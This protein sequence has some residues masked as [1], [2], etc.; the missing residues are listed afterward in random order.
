MRNVPKVIKAGLLRLIASLVPAALVFML[1]P[2]TTPAQSTDQEIPTPI[3]AADLSAEIPVR[4]LGDARRT[5]HFFIFT[6]TPGDLMVSVESRNLNG[7][8]DVFTAGSFRPL[9][10]ISLFASE[11]A[12]RTSKSVYLRAR[13]DLILRVEARSPNDEPGTYRLQFG[14]SFEPFSGEIAVAETPPESDEKAATTPRKG[15]RVNAV[16]ARID[17]PASVVEEK[18]A[19]EQPAI[20][21]PTP[22]PAK[23]EPAKSARNRAGRRNPRSARPKPAPKP[24]PAESS[25]TEGEAKSAE[26][27]KTDE[28]AVPPASETQ[29]ELGPRLIIETK[30]GVRIER[31]MSTVRRVVV[32]NGQIVVILRTGKIE[33][34]PL[35]SIVRMAIEP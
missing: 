32:D 4:D 17:E 5:Q 26:A 11:G 19:G 35:N 16:G 15:K 29:V 31:S 27:A 13:Q 8:V 25:T 22:E 30:E 21:T 7:D 1:A 23:P 33:R 24:K 34:T 28:P 6:G 3:R 2:G 20:E 9:F 10:K 12:S 18:A 14:G